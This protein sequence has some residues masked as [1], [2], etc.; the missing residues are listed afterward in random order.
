MIAEKTVYQDN[1]KLYDDWFKLFQSKGSII[2]VSFNPEGKPGNA[3]LRKNYDFILQKMLHEYKLI[4]EVESMGKYYMFTKNGERAAEIGMEKYVE[5]LKYKEGL[6]IEHLKSNIKTAKR[7]Q[8]ISIFALAISA[9]APVLAVIVGVHIN[10]KD[11]IENT[12]KKHHEYYK[13]NIPI[14]QD[15]ISN[16]G[17]VEDSINISNEFVHN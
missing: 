3:Q 9:I 4:M 17:A 14:G 7:S 2:N 5:E 16:N 10:K 15:S 11:N 8:T 12:I 6:E 13:Q 1:L